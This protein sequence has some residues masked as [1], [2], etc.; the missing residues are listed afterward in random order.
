MLHKTHAPAENLVLEGDRNLHLYF[1]RTGE[2]RVFV[3]V[4]KATAPADAANGGGTPTDSFAKRE[5]P[6]GIGLSMGLSLRSKSKSPAKDPPASAS[7]P[8][9]APSGAPSGAPSSAPRCAPAMDPVARARDGSPLG[10]RPPGAESKLTAAVRARDGSPQGGRGDTPL[11]GRGGTPLG[12]HG[13]T[14]L[15]ARGGTPLGARGGMG[16]APE[17]FERLSRRQQSDEWWDALTEGI[18]DHAQRGNHRGYDDGLPGGHDNEERRLSEVRFGPEIADSPNQRKASC[19]AFSNSSADSSSVAPGRRWSRKGS[20]GARCGG[21]LHALIDR[22]CGPEGLSE[23]RPVDQRDQREWS[24]SNSSGGRRRSR[25]PSALFMGHRSSFLY[26]QGRSRLGG[27]PEAHLDGLRHMVGRISGRRVSEDIV[28]PSEEE[29]RLQQMRDASVDDLKQLGSPVA[30]LSDGDAFG[31]QSF[32]TGGKSM[33]TVR[34][35]TFCEIMS[36]VYR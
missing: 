33:A 31:E 2:L 4:T 19:G 14:P 13:G 15:G 17:R 25:S 24:G 36:L 22:V 10:S 11:G 23:E 16:D 9:P 34:T 6:I 3:R 27:R 29:L 7:P 8:A 28:E 18:F 1:V 12:A 26:Q 20:L 5:S 32:L 30:R 21:S 35:I